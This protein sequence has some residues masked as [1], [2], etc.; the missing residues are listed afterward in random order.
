MIVA[1]RKLLL[2][3]A[4]FSDEELEKAQHLFSTERI[5]KE[6]YFSKAGRISDRIAFVQSGLLRSYFTIKE[7]ETTTFFQTPGSLA[8]ALASFLQMK[9]SLENIQALETSE[10]IVIS[11][12]NLFDLY[13]ENWKW[14]QVGRIF[15]EQYYIKME[16][17]LIIL[18]SQTAQDRYEYFLKEY[19]EL[20]QSVPLY[21]IASFLGMSPETL[22]R[23]RKLK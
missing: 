22:S 15:I 11:R 9:P 17:R 1:L 2:P 14:Q 5:E 16:Q 4:P 13:Q 18:Q 3:L 21:Y 10:L 20:I 6:K 8:T 12:K 23:I 19:P 7:K